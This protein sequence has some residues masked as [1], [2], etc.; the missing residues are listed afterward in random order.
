[1]SGT[2]K[3]NDPTVNVFAIVLWCSTN[4]LNWEG[5]SAHVSTFH[6]FVCTQSNHRSFLSDLWLEYIDCEKSLPRGSME[7]VGLLHWKAVKT[8]DKNSTSDFIEKFSLMK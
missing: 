6:L 1:M 8:L 3:W 2:C 4:K 5:G 7:K